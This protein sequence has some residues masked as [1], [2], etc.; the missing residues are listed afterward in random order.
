M[1]YKVQGSSSIAHSGTRRWYE[2]DLPDSEL[3]SSAGH[4]YG[5]T[6][7]VLSCLVDPRV[8]Y[9]GPLNLNL[10]L[11]V[12]ACRRLTLFKFNLKFK[13]SSSSLALPLAVVS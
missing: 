6:G 7:T 3:E 12:P 10:L 5:T 11:P 1:T 9:A 13:L 2:Y 4:W 8:Q